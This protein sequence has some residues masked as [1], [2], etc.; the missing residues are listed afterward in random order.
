MMFVI[1]MVESLA[2]LV[3][4]VGGVE[5]PLEG[6]TPVVVTVFLDHSDDLVAGYRSRVDD[7]VKWVDG[8]DFDRVSRESCLKLFQ[9]GN[10]ARSFGDVC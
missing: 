2:A 3:A 6:I 9:L 7:H 1:V 8:H 4:E 10:T 5:E